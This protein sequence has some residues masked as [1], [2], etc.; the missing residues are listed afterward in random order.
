MLSS[1]HTAGDRDKDVREIG[2]ANKILLKVD[3]GLKAVKDIVS[4]N[5]LG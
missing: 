1:R 4:N 5:D 2:E 3:Y